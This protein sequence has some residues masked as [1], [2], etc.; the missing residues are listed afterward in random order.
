M[1]SFSSVEICYISDG[2][3]CVA[4]RAASTKTSEIDAGMPCFPVRF[5][6]Q[7]RYAPPV[8]PSLA[9]EGAMRET[10]RT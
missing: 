1:F 6:R 7:S 2:S 5:V 4:T 9:T 8:L 3:Y 10:M